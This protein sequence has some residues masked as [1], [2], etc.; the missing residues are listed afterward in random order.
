MEDVQVYRNW[1]H[2]YTV[3]TISE[4]IEKS[5][6]KIITMVGS[7]TGEALKEDS[8]WIGIVAQKQ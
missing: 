1:F 7:L 3:K 6:F 4:I 2:D 5:G 8:E